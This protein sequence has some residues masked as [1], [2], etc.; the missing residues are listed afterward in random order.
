M[1]SRV[2]HAAALAI[3]VSMLVITAVE[4]SGNPEAQAL[5]GLELGYRVWVPEQAAEYAVVSKIAAT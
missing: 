5:L 2:A 4:R 3:A 1:P